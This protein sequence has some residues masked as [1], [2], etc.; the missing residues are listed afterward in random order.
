[1]PGFDVL[2]AGCFFKAFLLFIAKSGLTLAL[3]SGLLQS[4]FCISAIIAGE[5][6]TENRLVLSHLLT[7]IAG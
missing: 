5:R 4:A 7:V 1:V 3:S 6:P 2:F